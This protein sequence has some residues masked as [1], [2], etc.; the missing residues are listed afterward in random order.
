MITSMAYI[1]ER[2]T[3]TGKHFYELSVNLDGEHYSKR[4]YPPDGM[5]KR[6]ADKE[7]MTAA[8]QFEADCKSGKIQN[9]H[10]KNYLSAKLNPTLREYGEQIFMPAKSVTMSENSRASFQ[11][12]L[13]NRI[14]PALGDIRMQEITPTHIMQFLL[15]L[16]QEGLAHATVEKNYVILNLIF[17]MAF[18]SD[19]I[20]SNPMDK[21]PHPKRRK[22]EAR[23]SEIEAYTADEL[24]YI[25]NCLSQEPLK[26]RALV[27]LLAVTGIR[28]GECCGLQWEY[29][30]FRHNE[31]TIARTINY[32]SDKGIYEDTPKN[33]KA[34]TIPVDAAAMELLKQWRQ[35]Q[36][37]HAISRYVFTQEDSAEPMHP[38]SPEHYLKKFAR[39]YGI[40]DLH[41]HK[42]RHTFASVAITNGAD[43][44]SISEILGHCDKSVTLK[45][46]THADKESM[47]RAGNVF[48]DALKKST[49][50]GGA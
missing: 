32:T 43:I 29:V 17:K 49:A 11:S 38:Q 18:C 31:I 36:S 14:Y 5:S 21:V 1:R 37:Q 15:T 20:K 4:W 13:N 10:Q 16:Q 44:A 47:K 8:V 6:K 48:L 33:G 34:R 41:P 39:K 9:R 12:Y 27:T 40:K 24:I 3:K 25:L 35:E 22:S 26:W 2:M 50:G 28:R 19:L 45:M 23:R 46:Y 42:L 30:D 7:V